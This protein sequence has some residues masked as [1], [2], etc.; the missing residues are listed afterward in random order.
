MS[1]FQ[2][3]VWNL[4]TGLI[5]RIDLPHNTKNRLT[6]PSI[7]V[8]QSRNPGER[9]ENALNCYSDAD[10]EVWSVFPEL[11]MEIN[12]LFWWSG[13]RKWMRSSWITVKLAQLRSRS[14]Q[15]RARARARER[16][17]ERERELP[18]TTASGSRVCVCVW[19]SIENPIKLM[20][21]KKDS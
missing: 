9:R 6:F 5:A 17:R 11:H 18:I 12:A 15:A 10:C 13:S 14:P 20:S 2:S 1:V 21:V 8:S 7:R 3:D 16:E 19:E 4:F